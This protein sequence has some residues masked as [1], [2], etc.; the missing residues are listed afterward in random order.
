MPDD[1]QRPED[2][3]DLYERDFPR[4]AEQQAARLRQ[5][6]EEGLAPDLDWDHL[7]AEVEALGW[8]ETEGVRR[9]LLRALER[10]LCATAWPKAAEARRWADEAGSL[11]RQARLDWTPGMDRRLDPVAL[12]VQA[13]ASVRAQERENGPPGP[14]PEDCPVGLR[15]LLPQQRSLAVPSR[16]LLERFGAAAAAAATAASAPAGAPR[17]DPV[18]CPHCGQV[19]MPNPLADGSVTCSCPAERAL[20]LGDGGPSMPP[21]VDDASFTGTAP[22]GPAAAPPRRGATTAPPPRRPAPRAPLEGPAAA[23]GRL[24]PPVDE[25]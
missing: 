24:P 23:G 13:L 10:L 14:L 4:W 15:D 19:T 12:Y 2:P 16:I 5:V 20:P 3:R 25:E 17:W 9:R 6:A 21:P 22:G 11:L 1:T 18:E 8:S 7:I